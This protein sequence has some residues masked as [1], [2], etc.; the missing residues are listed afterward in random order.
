MHRIQDWCHLAGGSLEASKS[1]VWSTSADGRRRLAERLPDYLHGLC[2]RDLGIDVSFGGR[3]STSTH[4]KRVRKALSRLQRLRRL[5]LPLS[6]LERLIRPLILCPALWGGGVQQLSQANLHHLQRG[7][8]QL[9]GCK[10]AS[11]DLT[12]CCL[13]G[14]GMMN[15]L[16]A[17]HGEVLR[18]FRRVVLRAPH[19]RDQIC[20]E[21]QLA[22]HD[23]G[24]GEISSLLARVVE[25]LWALH[26]A[27]STAFVW[28]YGEI[29]VDIL[30]IEHGRF[31]HFL[32]DVCVHFSILRASLTRS[33]LD[34]V[35]LG[36]DRDL[37]Q[38]WLKTIKNPLVLS[39]L[40]GLLAGACVWPDR[41]VHQHPQL[42][43]CP[44]CQGRHV[45]QHVVW[46]CPDIADRCLT[47]PVRYALRRRAL[48]ELWPRCLV[49][50]ALVPV[51][52]DITKVEIKELQVY[53]LEIYD[54]YATLCQ[55][56]VGT[57][58]G[59]LPSE[60]APSWRPRAGVLRGHGRHHPVRALGRL[61]LATARRWRRSTPSS[62][63]L[64]LLES[65][66]AERQPH[67]WRAAPS[68]I[69]ICNVCGRW[70]RTLKDK[71]KLDD[72][73]CLGAGASH[74]AKCKQGFH[75]VR[76][77]KLLRATLV[78]AGPTHSL[79]RDDNKIWCL[80]CWRSV[81]LRQR[82]LLES[83]P[84]ASSTSANHRWRA[85]T[86]Q[87][88]DAELATFV[89]DACGLV[90]H[91]GAELLRHAA[92]C[93]HVAAPSHLFFDVRGAAAELARSSSRKRIALWGCLRCGLLARSVSELQAAI[94]NGCGKV[95]N[96]N[97]KRRRDLWR[98]D[99]PC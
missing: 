35:A 20:N 22:V 58:D 42:E 64:D 18:Q 36:I 45:H 84:C 47:S 9:F 61:S 44:G 34:G 77:A 24:R 13:K 53:L 7:V 60:D 86:T 97:Q 55:N 98:D 95:R 82:S 48:R 52:F 25:S 67:V 73:P 38:C 27:P 71:R 23:A 68:G 96:T 54:I 89:C 39:R 8:K 88:Y 65:T 1:T 87:F 75:V 50:H 3:V 5:G 85:S 62:K 72:M 74:K 93:G 6:V 59:A 15:P 91:D 43:L 70:A 41:R 63:P 57:G 81:A 32:R 56:I 10:A 29:R 12:L 2:V 76:D 28:Q 30:M 79:Q 16:A 99:L 26:L 80:R 49:E 33:S 31:S 4:V 66:R 78:N 11:S 21:W 94:A 51:G 83:S 46:S 90:V 14:G 37:T 40:R 92:P 69:S 17:Q 19:L